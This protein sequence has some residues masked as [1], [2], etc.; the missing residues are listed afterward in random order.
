M[1]PVFRALADDTRRGL[2]DELF[3][4]DGQTLTELEQR[5]AMTRFGVMK[6]LK[7]LEQAGLI[8]SRRRGREKLH[9]LNPVPIRLIYDRW[10]SKYSEPWVTSLSGLKA[11]LEA[12]PQ[13]PAGAI[14]EGRD[15]FYPGR[16]V[17]TILLISGSSR[18]GSTNAAVLRTAAALAPANVDAVSY[19]G[20]GG[21]PLFNPDDDREGTP[22]DE[23]VAAMRAAVASADAVLVCTPE[24]AGALPAALKNLLEWT[25]G[26]AGTYAK[27]VAWINAAGP[28]A[29]SGAADAHDSL[30]KVLGYAGAEI[31]ESA[32]LRAPVTREMVGADGLVHDDAARGQIAASVA[33]LADHVRASATKSA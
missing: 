1:D 25:I 8:T 22:V 19:A 32:C 14:G 31:A 17:I 3:Q 16:P 18:D 10:V 33:A 9:F 15:G 23:R 7:V 27:P 11:D 12:A 2:L 30:R 4:R 21:L 26:D 6:H 5:V 29:P 20:T 28:A 13:P 24:Y